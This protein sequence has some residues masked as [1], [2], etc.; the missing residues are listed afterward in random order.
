M[1]AWAWLPIRSPARPPLCPTVH[2]VLKL[3][4]FV[5]Q[6]VRSGMYSVTSRVTCTSSASS[7]SSAPAGQGVHGCLAPGPSRPLLRNEL[8]L[9]QPRLRRAVLPASQDDI[10][11]RCVRSLCLILRYAEHLT[12]P[13]L[14]LQLPLLS[15]GPSHAA[16]PLLCLGPTPLILTLC[17]R[18]SSS[19]TTHAA[20]AAPLS[21]AQ[22]LIHLRGCRSCPHSLH[23]CYT[24][25]S[26]WLCLVLLSPV[27]LR[28]QFAPPE[29]SSMV[30]IL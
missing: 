25:G 26:E 13:L 2:R 15:A 14:S 19:L 6:R 8:R 12:L 23:V 20:G 7:C 4:R 16:K 22:Q 5:L 11:E 28:I 29:G 30:A 17:L 21:R 9:S 3:V 27:T 18:P 24:P 1:W 10:T